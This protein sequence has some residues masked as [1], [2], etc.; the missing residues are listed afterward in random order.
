MA[1]DRLPWCRSEST[2]ATKSDNVMF[3]SIAIS[4]RPVQNASS[5]LTLVLWP[6]ITM[7][8]FTTGDF[9]ACLPFRYGVGLDCC[10]PCRFAIYQ[11]RVAPS[12]VHERAGSR[13]RLVRRD[14]AWPAS[15]GFGD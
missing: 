7:E 5:R 12:S 15:F 6:A 13:R 14:A 3:R 1:D 2:V 9:I 8:R 11:E 10:W 4:F